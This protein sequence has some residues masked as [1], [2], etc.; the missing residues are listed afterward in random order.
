ML[1]RLQT[2]YADEPVRFLLVPCNQF[3][4][5]EPA[6]NE[7]VKAFAEKSVHLGKGSNVVMLA[8]S[9]LN[10]VKCTYA[11]ADACSPQSTECCPANDAVYDYLLANTPPGTIAWNFDKIVTGTDGKPFSGEVIMHGGDIDEALSAVI[12]TLLVSWR[13]TATKL[14]AAPPAMARLFAAQLAFVAMCAMAALLV[15]RAVG[16]RAWAA[17]QCHEQADAEGYYVAVE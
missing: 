13:A 8:K 1:K 6:A 10:G 2:R 5:Q 4:G 11:G 9:N 14:V 7:A 15:W 16:T 3:G 12:G 17:S